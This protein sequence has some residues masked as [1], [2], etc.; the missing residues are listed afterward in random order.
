MHWVAAPDPDVNPDRRGNVS[1]LLIAASKSEVTV[2]AFCGD[3]TPM[4]V[5]MSVSSFC[6]TRVIA[7]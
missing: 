3:L 2:A 1:R 4:Y 5:A 7:T 6:A